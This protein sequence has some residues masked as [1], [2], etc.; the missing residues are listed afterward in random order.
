MVNRKKY[1]LLIAWDLI[2]IIIKY[3]DLRFCQI[4]SD[5]GLDKDRYNEEPDKT[6]ESIHASSFFKNKK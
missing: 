5:L 4:L 6:L 1:N 3:P 2:T